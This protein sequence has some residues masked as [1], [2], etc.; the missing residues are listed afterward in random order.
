MKMLMCGF[1]ISLGLWASSLHADQIVTVDGENYFLSHLM[2]N[3]QSITDDPAAQIS[4]FG[5]ISKLMEEQA[6]TTTVDQASV[7]E[8][9]E[10]LRAVAAY[11]NDDTGLL[12][13]GSGCTIQTVYFDNYFH[14]SRRN[15]SEIDLFSAQ[16]DAS[17][18]EANQIVREQGGQAPLS[19][20]VMK[21]GTAAVVRGGV[22]LDSA[23]D[24]FEPRSPEA[25]LAVYANEVAALI[26]AR[27]T[28]TFDFVLVH[29]QRR[30]ASAEIWNAFD[31]YVSACN[32]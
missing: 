2:A 14:V 17:K 23:R 15:I 8:K 20:G 28:E 11:Q 19:R 22:A 30:G 27:E 24:A 12:I 31:A 26:E 18:L 21:S 32:G 1:T 4:C 10:A 7:G 9:L 5:A 13:T 6:V 25:T 29:P 3:C 16:F